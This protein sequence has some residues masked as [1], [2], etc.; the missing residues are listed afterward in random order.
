MIGASRSPAHW[1]LPRRS[2]S[3]SARRPVTAVA[4]YGSR[5]SLGLTLNLAHD[6]VRGLVG[7]VRDR[8]GGSLEGPYEYLPGL[9]ALVHGIPYYLRH[10]AADFH[11]PARCTSKATRRGR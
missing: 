7:G 11:V 1:R 10:F 4:L 5:C 8:R 9:P 6:G 2:S 3:G